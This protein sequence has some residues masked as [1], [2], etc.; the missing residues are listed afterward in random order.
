M[1]NNYEIIDDHTTQEQE[2]HLGFE[3]QNFL[4]EAYKWAKFLAVLGFVACGLM[5]LGAFI[6]IIATANEVGSSVLMFI[7]I[8]LIAAIYFAP[9]YYLFMF[10]DKMK[11]G[12]TQKHNAHITSSFD[13]L[14]R[15]FKFTGMLAIFILS[16][17]FIYAVFGIA[18]KAF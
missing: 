15:F 6:G 13:Y 14:K 7:I 4:N 8:P 5:L 12:L 16:I 9:A 2:L 10:S 1:E 17:Y 18:S 11:K 3:S